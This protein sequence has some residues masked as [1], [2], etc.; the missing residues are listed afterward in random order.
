MSL[1]RKRISTDAIIRRIKALEERILAS[2]SPAV[3]FVDF[4]PDGSI[5]VKAQ[6]VSAKG[7][8][9]QVDT[10]TFDSGP[11]ALEYL[12]GIT[13]KN[14]VIVNTMALVP[15]RFYVDDSLFFFMSQTELDHL[16]IQG[17]SETGYMAFYLDMARKYAFPYELPENSI[18]SDLR[19][20][21]DE[22]SLEQLV[23]RYSDRKWFKHE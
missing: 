8:L 3:T 5:V 17:A 11:A 14:P 18:L 22:L 6:L 19:G 16:Y 15:D 2:E 10:K 13:H 7:T 23:E 20:C 9:I 12:D 4:Q 1:N 21:C